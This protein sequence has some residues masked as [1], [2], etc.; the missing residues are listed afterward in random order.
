MVEVDLVIDKFQ[1][2]LFRIIRDRGNVIKYLPKVFVDKTL[3]GVLLDFY[4]IRHVENFVDTG[5]THALPC[6]HLHLMYHRVHSSISPHIAVFMA[7]APLRHKH[8]RISGPA[9]PT[10]WK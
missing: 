6:A 5:E 7:A 2:E 8:F 1:N 10:I 4:Q 9:Y 3:I